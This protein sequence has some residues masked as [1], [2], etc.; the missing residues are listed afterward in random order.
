MKTLDILA[1]LILCVCV[2]DSGIESA[3]EPSNQ[4]STR[5]SGPVTWKTRLPIYEHV[6]SLSVSIPAARGVRDRVPGEFKAFLHCFLTAYLADLYY[7]NTNC[8]GVQGD[9]IEAN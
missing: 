8:V 2:Q 4:S 1:D 5:R 3:F 9:C 7:A 6:A